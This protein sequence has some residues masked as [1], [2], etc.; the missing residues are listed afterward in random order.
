MA[1]DKGTQ[2]GRGRPIPGIFRVHEVFELSIPEQTVMGNDNDKKIPLIA[3]TNVKG[4]VQGLNDIVI[5]YEGFIFL[6][7]TSAAS[8]Q[9]GNVGLELTLEFEYT[10]GGTLKIPT[11][12]VFRERLLR[13]QEDTKG[14]TIFDRRIRVPL[15]EVDRGDGQK[16]TITQEMLDAQIGVK[17]D[18]IVS[19]YDQNFNNKVTN[20]NRNV[21]ISGSDL[22]LTFW[23]LQSG[24]ALPP[25]VHEAPKTFTYG[26]WNET[27]AEPVA[28]KTGT[29][30]IQTLPARLEWTTPTATANYTTES[31]FIIIPDGSILNHI[32]LDGARDDQDWMIDSSYTGPGTRYFSAQLGSDTQTQTA[33]MVTTLLPG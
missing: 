18:L 16:I 13:G 1:L 30:N 31:W 9:A 8:G 26:L 2:V 32:Y 6:D 14:F 5:D 4:G 22:K 29:L 11:R 24:D 21:K 25:I 12:R 28:G 17:L 7:N 3:Q 20:A 23:Q 15:G 10:L 19:L 33:D 27:D